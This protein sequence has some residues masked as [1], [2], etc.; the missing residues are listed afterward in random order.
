MPEELICRVYVS[1]KVPTFWLSSTPCK[2]MWEKFLHIISST[3]IPSSTFHIYFSLSVGSILP[4]HLY[5]PEEIGESD[6][7]L[8]D[9]GHHLKKL[10]PNSFGTCYN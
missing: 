3:T 9:I 10:C 7:M 6:C 8:F 5:V 1:G 2:Y 4:A